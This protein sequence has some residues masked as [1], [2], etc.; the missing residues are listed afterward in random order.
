MGGSHHTYREKRS[1]GEITLVLETASNF[2]VTHYLT[3]AIKVGIDTVEGWRYSKMLNYSRREGLSMSEESPH[4]DHF[5]ANS[6]V[7][8][9]MG[10]YY[11]ASGQN[12]RAMACYAAQVK[13]D[14]RRQ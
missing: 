9:I 2:L 13:G 10:N 8:L 5:M 11:R 7:G 4:A 12:I 14:L 1:D 3:Q 6:E